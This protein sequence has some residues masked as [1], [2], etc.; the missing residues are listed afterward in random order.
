VQAAIALAHHGPRVTVKAGRHGA[1]SVA[2]GDPATDAEIV[3]VA[4]HAV[5]VLDTTGAGDTFDAA[6]I[7]TWLDDRSVRQCLHRAVAAGASAVSAIGGTAGQP[8]REDLDLP[9]ET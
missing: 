7:D 1:L 8:R 9:S 2:I 3:H 5:Q 6:F 4:A